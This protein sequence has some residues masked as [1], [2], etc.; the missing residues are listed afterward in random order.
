MDPNNN[1]EIYSELRK[2]RQEL[3]QRLQN[4]NG[5]PLVRPYI[6]GELQDIETALEKLEKGTYGTCE[7]SGELM[8]QDLLMMIP[9]LKSMNDC[10]RVSYFFR[11]S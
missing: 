4:N 2:T 8:P 9:T 10:Q 6:E 11:K 7:I 3:I 5:S 1:N